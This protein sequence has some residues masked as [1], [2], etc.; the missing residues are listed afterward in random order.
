MSFPIVLGHECSGVVEKIG[1]GV[2]RLSVGDRVV[3]RPQ[4]VCGNVVLV[5]KEDIIFVN[6]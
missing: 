2:T 1:T 3:L 5:E 6:H 4:D